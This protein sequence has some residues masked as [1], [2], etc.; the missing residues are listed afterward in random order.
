MR[1]TKKK[2]LLAMAKLSRGFQRGVEPPAGHPAHAIVYDGE[3]AHATN[4]T[5]WLSVASPQNITDL[6]VIDEPLLRTLLKDA[7]DVYIDEDRGLV[8]ELPL[9]LPS[10][11][12]PLA[13]PSTGRPL[14]EFDIALDRLASVLVAV[15]NGD[16]RYY[17]NGV[18][19]DFANHALVGTNGHRLHRYNSSTL[20]SLPASYEGESAPVMPRTA[21]ELMLQLKLDHV[22]WD[23][24]FFVA[25]RGDVELRVAAIDGKFPDY[26][27]VIRKP[28]SLELVA[29]LER[30][31]L[32]EA[33]RMASALGKA[34]KAKYTGVVLDPATAAA[35]VHVSGEQIV[36]PNAVR[37]ISISGALNP[38]GF[39]PEYLLDT[40]DQLS[41][42]AVWRFVNEEV[43]TARGSLCID[44]GEFNAVVMPMNI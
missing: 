14:V 13:L 17:L 40:V 36:L 7:E 41:A 31:P 35:T 34:R 3:R 32:R 26:G 20:P 11:P 38:I 25:S 30:E 23:G 8:N 16:I 33:L 15:A 1:I 12:G 27:K 29:K 39:N 10:F 9:G 4:G 44:D 21:A 24:K 42:E 6:S 37:A 28:S 19:L 22:V 2:V 18:C 5:V 43:H